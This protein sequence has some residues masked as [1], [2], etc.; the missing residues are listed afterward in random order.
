MSSNAFETPLYCDAQLGVCP[1]QPEVLQT[2]CHGIV[3]TMA[4]GAGPRGS[5]LRGRKPCPLA[6]ARHPRWHRRATAPRR[7]GASVAIT[8][9]KRARS[10]KL[11]HHNLRPHGGICAVWGPARGM[12]GTHQDLVLQAP[13]LAFCR[14][15]PRLARVSSA[16][17]ATPSPQAPRCSCARPVLSGL[18][19]GAGEAKRREACAR[20]ELRPTCALNPATGASRSVPAAPTLQVTCTCCHFILQGNKRQPRQKFPCACTRMR[21]G[22]RHI[23]RCDPTSAWKPRV[24]GNGTCNEAPASGCLSRWGASRACGRLG[25]RVRDGRLL[26]GQRQHLL[27]IVGGSLSAGSVAPL[28]EVGGGRRR[29]KGPCVSNP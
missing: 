11:L 14:R 5:N 16:S 1:R 2:M 7:A 22:R 20:V 17:S 21:N 28:P 12:R 9:S 4:A 6:W 18:D 13:V 23:V 19:A 26:H 29:W 3:P 25:Q 24:P 27:L 10:P 15:L 8:G